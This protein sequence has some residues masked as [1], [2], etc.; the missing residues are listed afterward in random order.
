[1]VIDWAHSIGVHYVDKATKQSCKSVIFRFPTFRH[2]TIAYR[3]KNNKNL[4]R[5]KID[6]TKNCYNL[7]VSANKYVSNSDS[8]KFCY[9]DVNCRLKIKWK[10]ESISDTSFEESR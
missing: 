7:L 3:A 9:G 4:V 2:R 10:N 1:M 5:F 8:V 6:L